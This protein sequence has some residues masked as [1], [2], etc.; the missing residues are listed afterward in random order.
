MS[1]YEKENMLFLQRYI[2]D[3]PIS[4]EEILQATE[5]SYKEGL[6]STKEYQKVISDIEAEKYEERLKEAELKRLNQDNSGDLLIN[7]F[8]SSF[9][10]ASLFEKFNM[11]VDELADYYTLERKYEYFNGAKLKGIQIRKKIHFLI[12]LI[13]KVDQLLSK[14]KM[15]NVKEL[16]Q[17]KSFMTLFLK[18]ETLIK[19]IITS[20]NRQEDNK[21]K[22]YACTHIGGND[23]Q[24]AFQIIKDPAWLMFG[25]PGIVYKKIIYQGLRI[26]GVL[27]LNTF[28]KVDRGITYNRA[29]ELLLNGGN[30]LIFPEGA[31]NV[32]PNELV[33]KI[34]VGAVKLALASGAEII[35]LALEQY[36]KTFYYNLGEGYFIPKNTNKTILELR[37]ELREK[38]ATLKWE[39]L[40]TQPTLK[41]EDIP[42]N[43][44]KEFQKEIVERCNYGYGFGLEDA[45][46]E[47]FHDKTIFSAEEVFSPL[48]NL[49]VNNNNAF[50]MKDKLELVL[51]KA[52]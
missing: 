38:L 47:K 22:I 42:D 16:Q 29:L 8:L 2:K 49:D 11:S 27:P 40:L 3:N 32:T 10:K 46:R 51:K 39:I 20:L 30:L 21:P 48:I 37:D 43:Y 19:E 25:N 26:N 44:L 24:R 6:I 18:I 31:W 28:D 41:R 5:E 7:G 1:F 52:A 12:S 9:K 45:L 33:M 13:L 23:I 17:N 14:E 34:F 50:L 36:G 35:P 15:V 4:L